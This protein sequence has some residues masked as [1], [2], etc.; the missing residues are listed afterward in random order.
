MP[1][2][3]QELLYAF[4]VAALVLFILAGIILLV[5]RRHSQKVNIMNRESENLKIEY[6]KGLLKSKLE[7]EEETRKHIAQELH[8]NLGSLASLIKINLNLYSSEETVKRKE[9]L[10]RESQQLI[11]QLIME[12]KQLSLQLNSDRL[13]QLNL[14]EM[15]QLDVTHLKKLDFFQ[16]D[17]IVQGEEP[18]LPTDKRIILYRICQEIIHN[19]LKHAQPRNLCIEV[20]YGDEDITVRIEDDG[21]G[22]DPAL[23]T[24]P[25]GLSGSGLVNMQARARIINGTL[26]LDSRKGH[27][28]RC[29][30][31]VPIDLSSTL[32]S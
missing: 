10:F 32:F 24:V 1:T 5:V 26:W 14:V 13:N 7:V 16:V 21:I 20:C 4:I 3:S 30:I 29:E 17:L 15:L 28:T 19:C 9:D 23:P 6:E 12:L 22:F 18:S 31:R 8:D 27:G 25:S 2:Q 11:R